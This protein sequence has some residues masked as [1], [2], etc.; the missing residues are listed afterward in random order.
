MGFALLFPTP[1]TNPLN[2]TVCRWFSVV[3]EGVL[4]TDDGCVREY[5]CTLTEDG[6]K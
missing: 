2:T 1:P 4:S 6:G 5:K 3:K